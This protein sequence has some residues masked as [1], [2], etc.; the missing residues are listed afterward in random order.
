MKTAR[1]TMLAIDVLSIARDGLPYVV[2]SPPDASV[3]AWVWSEK[4]VEKMIAQ[5][6]RVV[7]IEE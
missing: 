3:I 7:K 5:G 1:G 2:E 6:W 4:E